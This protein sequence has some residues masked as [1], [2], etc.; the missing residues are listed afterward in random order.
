MKVP[1]NVL[2]KITS[3]ETKRN[4]NDALPITG[5]MRGCAMATDK[6]KIFEWQ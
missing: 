1:N 5:E 4:G 2:L 6:P 3:A